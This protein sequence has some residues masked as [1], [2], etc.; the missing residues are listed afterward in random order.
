VAALG[1]PIEKRAWWVIGKVNID[2][3]GGMANIDFPHLR[4]EKAARGYMQTA[5]RDTEAWRYST[6]VVRPA[7]GG[8]IDILQ[9]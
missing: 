6:L 1:T 7:A 4:P 8:Q 2:D 9:H 3:N 5:S